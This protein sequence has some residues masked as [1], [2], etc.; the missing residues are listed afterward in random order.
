MTLSGLCS[1]NNITYS[2]LPRITVPQKMVR[3]IDKKMQAKREREQEQ[4]T[5]ENYWKRGK[6]VLIVSKRKELN[7][8]QGQ[9]FHDM[10][11][12]SLISHGWKH[13]KA[14]GDHFTLQN[15]GRIPA[16]RNFGEK[17]FQDLGLRTDLVETLKGTGIESPVCVQC[18]AIPTILKKDNIL[19]TAETGSGKTLAYLLPIIQSILESN[20]EEESNAKP[21]KQ[22]HCL[23]LLP[24]K[25]LVIQVESV[26]QQFAKTLSLNVKVFCQ[27]RPVKSDGNAIDIL[28]ATPG[29]CLKSV[30]YGGY[31]LARAKH[32]VLDE[33]DTLLDDSFHPYISALL[34][35]S[36]I[37]GS[38]SETPSNFGTQ[39]ILVGA[40]KPR[41]LEG[42]LGD[43]IPLDSLTKVNAPF[44]HKLPPHIPQKFLRIG[45]DDRPGAILTT[46]TKNA[47]S[48]IPTIVFCN[49]SSTAHW[50]GHFFEDSG[51]SHVLLT[52]AMPN[53]IRDGRFEQFQNGETNLL[54]TTDIAS[55]GL[56]TIR[57]QHV[58][59]YEF[60]TF[61]SDY[62]HRV[63]RLG[64]LGSKCTGFV[65]N[66]ITYRF[67]VELVWQIEIAAR[68]AAGLHNV[69]AN[70][71]R[72]LVT[73]AVNSGSEPMLDFNGLDEDDE[74]DSEIPPYNT[75]D[76]DRSVTS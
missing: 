67:D 22:P 1:T 10:D 41:D 30:K 29:A 23:I 38:S 14:K 17:S 66:Y 36:Q 52:G 31:S 21:V 12:K 24:T 16:L 68:K 70:I 40:T 15:L 26:V 49:K 25:E 61:M 44:L 43:I 75:H 45:P 60:P 53:K 4:K 2:N 20:S 32:I 33:A 72:K 3:N 18:E 59:N 71:K 69:N 5:R 58:I 39:M 13:F 9:R 42:I 64:R 47:K 65:L 35:E 28:I 56:D 19:C 51:T 11:E 54:V 74:D 46:V 7:V 50:M 57:A 55:R 73:K 34:K 6:K 37:Q 48:N 8:Y 63:G 27:G 76:I 62:I